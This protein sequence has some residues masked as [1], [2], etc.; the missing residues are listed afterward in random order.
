MPLNQD[1]VVN[2]QAHIVARERDIEVQLRR[3]MVDSTSDVTRD[4]AYINKVAER[5]ACVRCSKPLVSSEQCTLAMRIELYVAE[6]IKAPVLIDKLLCL[7]QGLG[8][9]ITDKPFLT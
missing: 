4:A 2:G 6:D 5:I 7:L 8:Y 9:A 1:L 3:S